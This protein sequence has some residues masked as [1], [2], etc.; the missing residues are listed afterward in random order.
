[1]PR[2]GTNDCSKQTDRQIDIPF[3]GIFQPEMV[4]GHGGNS[5]HQCGAAGQFE[6]DPGGVVGIF[7]KTGDS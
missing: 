7:V 3:V 6:A 2:G 5:P 1:M 4:F